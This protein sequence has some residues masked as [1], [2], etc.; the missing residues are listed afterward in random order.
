[1]S[2]L[3]FFMATSTLS[4]HTA[5]YVLTNVLVVHLKYNRWRCVVTFV[6]KLSQNVTRQRHLLV[7]RRMTKC[8]FEHYS[9]PSPR[10]GEGLQ[11]T[12][13]ITSGKRWTSRVA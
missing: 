9:N 3:N 12:Q 6:V 7:A 4:V 11:N 2:I 5:H 10:R 8:A 13:H 1:M